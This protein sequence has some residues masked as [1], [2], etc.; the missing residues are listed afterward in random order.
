MVV[1]VINAVHL[2]KRTEH[3]LKSLD[4]ESGF[5]EVIFKGENTADEFGKWLFHETH[6]NTIVLAHNSKSFDSVFLL[7][8]LLKNNIKPNKILFDGTKIMLMEIERRLY[9][10]VR[11]IKNFLPMK[12]GLLPKTFGFEQLSKGYFQ[13][14][15]NTIT[16]QK[17]KSTL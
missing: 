10:R 15:F 9:I 12:L 11:F 2:I 14:Y 1:D 5:R 7:E 4:K 8:Y 13:H 16:N 6:R 17:Y 3:I